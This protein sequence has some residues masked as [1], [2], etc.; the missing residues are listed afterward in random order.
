[1]NKVFLL[2]TNIILSK[3][4]AFD[5]LLSIHGT[6]DDNIHIVWL[7]L[8]N[9][10]LQSDILLCSWSPSIYHTNMYTFFVLIIL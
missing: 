1:M 4:S 6:R 9:W 10:P 8:E 2:C 3:I 5:H 7:G